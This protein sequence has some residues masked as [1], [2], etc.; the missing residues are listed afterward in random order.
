MTLS[1]LKTKNNTW[2]SKENKRFFGDRR[3]YVYTYRQKSY[4]IRLSSGWSDM[5]GGS[6]QELYF[7][8][9]LDGYKIE[10]LISD[11][12]LALSFKTLQEAKEYIKSL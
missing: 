4:L 7:I 3:Y 1:E 10:S 5:F 2:F 8:N 11:K 12:E 9:P 6:K